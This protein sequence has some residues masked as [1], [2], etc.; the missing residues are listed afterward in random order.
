[1]NV[2]H[3]PGQICYQ[4]SRWTRPRTFAHVWTA[5]VLARSLD[6]SGFLPQNIMQ[7]K[8]APLWKCS[9][10]KTV[11]SMHAD[12]AANH[13]A[14]AAL[15]RAYDVSRLELFGSAA[16]EHDFN[17]QTSDIDVL[18]KF[19]PDS[20]MSALK[21]FFGL[22]GELEAL[23]GRRVDLVEADAIENPFVQA[24]VDRSRRLIYGA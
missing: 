5:R 7:G 11:I 12:I 17:P 22:A 24:A 1:M 15:C 21:Q 23:F 6:F 3:H 9:P 4:S 10:G 19:N 14:L 16:R 13:E 8:I 20:S 2:T 18:V